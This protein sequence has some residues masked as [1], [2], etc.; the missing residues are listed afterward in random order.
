MI[1]VSIYDLIPHTPNKEKG[2]IELYLIVY[3][4]VGTKG[5]EGWV[6]VLAYVSFKKKNRSGFRFWCEAG[7]NCCKVKYGF[8]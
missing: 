2:I 3:F 6:K 4:F 5:V 7:E 1:F 8:K